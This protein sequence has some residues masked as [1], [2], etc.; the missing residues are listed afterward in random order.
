MDKLKTYA[1][2]GQK[3]IVYVRKVDVDDLPAEMREK[4]ADAGLTELYAIGDEDG[5]QLAFARDRQMAFLVARQHD[6]KPVSV[7]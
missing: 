4:A 2:P 3:P 5:Q 1:K 6:M 7:H